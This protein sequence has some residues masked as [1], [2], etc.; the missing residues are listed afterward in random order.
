MNLNNEQLGSTISSLRKERGLTQKQLG[1]ML[2][3]TDKTVS[4]WERGISMPNIFL[5]VPLSEALGVSTEELLRGTVGRRIEKRIESS[6]KLWALLYFLSAAISI[7][8]LYLLNLRGFSWLMMKDDSFLIVVLMLVF[9][10]CFC[11]FVKPVLPAYYDR[12]KI[13]YYSNG[14]LRINMPGISFNNSNW[15]YLLRYFRISTMSV[16]VL[17]PLCA[18]IFGCELW[19]KFKSIFFFAVMVIFVAGIYIT[20]KRNE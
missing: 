13:G 3:V 6:K 19:F 18:L 8:E 17:Y 5:L 20:A 16:A 7:A 14:F 10:G 11:F 4:K 9:G 1:E 15:F 12:E 2:F